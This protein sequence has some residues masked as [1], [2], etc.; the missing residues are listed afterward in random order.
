MKLYLS[1]L[2]VLLLPVTTALAQDGVLKLPM[3]RSG[4]IADTLARRSE[5]NTVDVHI[6]NQLVSY[7][8]DI[9]VG[10]PAQTLTVILDTGSSDLWFP[11]A[12]VCPIQP[13]CPY[14]SCMS[15]FFLLL[16]G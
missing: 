4:G 1:Q 5:D 7:M 6:S 14:G 16:L 12:T 8:V 11:A 9:S 10:T 13:I 15:F 3:K 2:A